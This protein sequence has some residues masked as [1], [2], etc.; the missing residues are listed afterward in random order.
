MSARKDAFLCSGM[1][2]ENLG[3]VPLACPVGTSRQA[4]KADPPIKTSLS[5][6]FI[7]PLWAED[8][9][10]SGLVSPRGGWLAPSVIK[11]VKQIVGGFY[12]AQLQMD[13]HV[14][15]WGVTKIRY[16]DQNLISRPHDKENSTTADTATSY[17][18]C[19]QSDAYRSG[20]MDAGKALPLQ[21]F[22]KSATLCFHLI[23]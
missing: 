13:L 14:G 9:L 1:K 5:Q 15:W 16:V 11:T 12:N 18:L 22:N 20:C 6:S 7:P 21:D 10:V 3:L 2:Y 19:Y 4:V 23:R 8:H 17:Q